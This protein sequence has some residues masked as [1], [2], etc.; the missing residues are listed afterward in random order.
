[1]KQLFQGIWSK[2][3]A[4][5]DFKTNTSSRLYLHEAPQGTSLPYAVYFMVDGDH[6][7]DFDEQHNYEEYLLQFNI[8][9]DDR[10]EV[11]NL[12]TNCKSMF[13]WTTLTVTGYTFL[14]MRREG[15]RM[16]RADDDVW[17]YVVEYRVMVQS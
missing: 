5:G 8:F 3:N 16:L 2:Y 4:G 6:D 12:F 7:W 11:N 17:Q 13:D 9:A 15:S 10:L 14:F 1:M